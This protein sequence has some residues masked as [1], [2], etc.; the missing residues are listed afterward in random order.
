[1]TVASTTTSALAASRAEHAHDDLHNLIAHAA[2]LLPSQGPIQVFVHHNT[3]HAFEPLP[4]EEAMR[5]GARA[6]GCQTYLSEDRYRQELARGRILQEDL[7][8]VLR[9]DLGSSAGDAAVFADTRYEFRLSMLLYPLRIASDSELRW[10][11]AETDALRKFPAEGAPHLRQRMIDETR[12][13]VM[14]SLRNG[15]GGG[16]EGNRR[17]RAALVDLFDHFGRDRMEQWSDAVWEEFTLNALWR[18]CHQGAHGVARLRGGAAVGVRPRDLILQASGRDADLLVHEFLIPFCGAFLDQG[19]ACWT[20]PHR[21]LGFFQS[22]SRLYRMP[23]SLPYRW[24][25]GLKAELDRIDSAGITPLESIEESLL[26]LNVAP[27]ETEPFLTETLLALRGWAGML[28][29]ME[30]NAEWTIRPAPPGTLVEFL[31]VRLILDRLALESA[32][33]DGFEFNGPVSDIPRAARHRISLQRP[34]TLEQRA[35]LIF[36]LALARGWKPEDLFQ[37][38]KS[39]WTGLVEEIE[40]FDGLERRRVYHAAYERHYFHRALDA[41]SVASRQPLQ[42]PTARVFQ[43]VTCLDDREESF[44][45]HL[46]EVE[47]ACETFGAAGFYSAAMYYRGAADAHF[48]PLCPV[49]VK[50]QHYVQEEVAYTFHGEHQRRARTRRALGTASHWFHTGSRS[51]GSGVMT[52]LVGSLASLPM[53]MRILFPRLTARLRKSFSRVVQPPPVTQLRLERKEGQPSPEEDG[54]GFTVEEM[55]GVVTRLLQDIGLTSGFARLFV[56]TGHG[57]S[58]LNNPHESAYNCG[59][60][61]GGRGG[62]NARAFAQM[63]NDPR[64]RDL[65]AKNGIEIPPTTVFVGCFHNTCDDSVTWFDLDRLPASH[66]NDWDATRRV[67][68]L[69]RERNAHER[70][71]RFESAPFSLTPEAALR[72]V[73]ERAEDLSQ[74]R[75]EYNHATNAITVVARRSRTRG[76]FLDRRAFLTSYDPEQDPDGQVLAR[77]LSAVIPVCAGISLEYYFSCVDVTSLGCGSKLPHNIASLL[78]VMEGAQSDLRTGLSQQMIEIHEPMRPLFILETQPEIMQK[79]IAGNP[80]IEVLCRNDWVLIATLDPHSDA[81]HLLKDG[82]FEAY[83]PEHKELPRVMSSHD[84]YRGWRDHLGFALIGQSG[85]NGHASASREGALA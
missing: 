1:V 84:W 20:L 63:A 68:D 10:L 28:W 56:V 26:L 69:A 18:V 23:G 7:E 74:A 55:A 14:R 49:I 42:K 64:V 76:L 4:F 44:R 48:I 79:I 85:G 25:S 17:A 77:I 43:L 22:F 82:R 71:R 29:Q 66:R 52:S 81:I 61:G 50:P 51:F 62:P 35:F 39:Q 34:P 21:D 78:G 65:V 13:W 15:D 53:V 41:V 75:P 11:M 19:V 36:Q 54:L 31:A 46:E 33:R 58:S 72:H 38:Q 45:R 24:L 70:C 67:I 73:E 2:H 60:C 3:L 80:A 5:V 59:A 9:E 12:H 6:Y 40:A 83:R 30:T 47:P 16:F 27:E 37:L 32:A 57:S 8:A